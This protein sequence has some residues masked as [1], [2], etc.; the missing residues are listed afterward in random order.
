MPINSI[1]KAHK[2]PIYSSGKISFNVQYWEKRKWVLSTG[3]HL[4]LCNIGKVHMD[5]MSGDHIMMSSL[6]IGA[7][8]L[9]Q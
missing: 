4:N 6:K 9:Y 5:L 7:H 2:N 8:G 3:I 1:G